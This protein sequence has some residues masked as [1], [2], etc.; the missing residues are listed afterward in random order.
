MGCQQLVVSVALCEELVIATLTWIQQE[1]AIGYRNDGVLRSAAGSLVGVFYAT[2][3]HLVGTLRFGV[4]RATSSKNLCF[5]LTRISRW[6]EIPA[7]G[8]SADLRYATSFGLVAATPFW[9]V[10]KK[11]FAIVAAGGIR[12]VEKKCVC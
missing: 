2:P 9:V 6:F 1:R 11:A 5:S 7:D 12:F 4:T 10:F 8:S 3:F